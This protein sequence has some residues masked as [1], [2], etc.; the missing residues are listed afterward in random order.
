MAFIMEADKLKSVFRQSYISD[1]SRKENDAE[2]SWHLSLMVITLFEYA[3]QPNLDLLRILKMVIL[4]DIV[5]IDAGDTYIY[6]EEAKKDQ[7]ERERRAAKR[8]FGLLPDDQA[9]EYERIWHEFET[10][11][12]PEARFAKA[13]DR[14]QPMLLNYL[15]AGRAWQEHNVSAEQ[16]RAINSP[17][18]EGSDMLWSYAQSIIKSAIQNGSLPES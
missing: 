16:V 18:A 11:A 13:V 4:H 17:I 5:E 3:N 8:L 2:H 9:A 10:A 1:E 7:E 15:A 6:D 12:T 14:L